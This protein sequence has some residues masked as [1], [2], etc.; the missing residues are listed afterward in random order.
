MLDKIDNV[1][2]FSDDNPY[3]ML[4]VKPYIIY[5]FFKIYKQLEFLEKKREIY[6]LLR[7]S[8]HNPDFFTM[9]DKHFIVG[10]KSNYF[11]QNN[12]NEYFFYMNN[13]LSIAEEI[14]KLIEDINK[15]LIDKGLQGQLKYNEL[16][17]EVNNKSIELN[18][19][20]LYLYSFLH[21]IGNKWTNKKN[22]FLISNTYGRRKFDTAKEF[23]M[24]E[25]NAN[26][27]VPIIHI[28]YVCTSS[29]YYIATK[30]LNKFLENEQ[31]EW[32]ED[33]HSEIM[34]LDGLLPQTNLGFLRINND[35]SYD[36]IINPWLVKQI[37][38]KKRFSWTAGIQIDQTN[39]YKF[40]NELGYNKFF[41]Q[42]IDGTRIYKDINDTRVNHTRGFHTR[43]RHN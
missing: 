29:R 19:L 14:K 37:T 26:D 9:L 20:R 21:N 10:I 17:R 4:E 42:Y 24:T 34:M 36:L 18:D 39:F 12:F 8:R 32:Y 22:S 33:I 31:I 28:N 13:N 38:N 2:T 27:T 25:N 35:D 23:A 3:E 7:G 40:A 41:E 11:M 6:L 30:L 43:N 15:I 1:K 5:E 16:L